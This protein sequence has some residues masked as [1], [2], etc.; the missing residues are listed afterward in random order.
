MGVKF[1]PTPPI[2]LH[3]VKA[4]HFTLHEA[5]PFIYFMCLYII[6][7]L[8]V[9]SV[10]LVQ[11]GSDL[12]VVDAPRPFIAAPSLDVSLTFNEFLPAFSSRWDQ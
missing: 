5:T 10:A 2:L 11:P 1:R 4:F 6:S 3:S 9:L 7:V 8:P 12:V